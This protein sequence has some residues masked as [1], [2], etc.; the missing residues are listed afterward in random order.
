MLLPVDSLDTV[1]CASQLGILDNP[2]IK[3]KKE[4]KP[5]KAKTNQPKS[6]KKLYF[7]ECNILGQ[8]CL[9]KGESPL[10]IFYKLLETMNC[11]KFN[12]KAVRFPCI[13]RRYAMKESS[14]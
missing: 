11:L 3:N 1:F 14:P 6:I 13:S 12:R 10:I 8:F 5:N 2:L 9:S 7:S 4:K